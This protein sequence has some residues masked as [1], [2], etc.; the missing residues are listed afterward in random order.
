MSNFYKITDANALKAISDFFDK[1]DKFYADVKKMCDHYGFTHHSSTDSIVFGIRF[2]NMCA[3]PRTEKIDKDLWKTA[4]IKN[5]HMVSILPRATAKDH[6]AIHDAMKPKPMDY[7]D[8]NKLILR[9]DVAP[10]SKTYGY[11]YKKDEYFMF[12]TSL[13]VSDLSVEILG[14]EYGGGKDDSDD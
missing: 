9:S 1:R 2:N 3:D 14:S 13:E 12:T 5:S 7:S 11:R 4:K 6:K 8:L 10:W